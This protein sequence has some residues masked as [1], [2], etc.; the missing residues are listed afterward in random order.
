MVITLRPLLP[1]SLRWRESSQ[2]ERSVQTHRRR[3][4]GLCGR[5]PPPAASRALNLSSKPCAVYL[6]LTKQVLWMIFW[7]CSC[8]RECTCIPCH[9]HLSRGCFLI[10]PS[11]DLMASACRIE[12]CSLHRE[13]ILSW[14]TA[15]R[16][17]RRPQLRHQ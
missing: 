16:A 7:H 14:V 11:T 2:S 10:S 5:L 15:R 13:S 17:V 3:S 6:S 12:Q 4:H 1:R 9:K 8:S